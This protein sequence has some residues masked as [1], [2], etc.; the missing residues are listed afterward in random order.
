MLWHVFGVLRIS[1]TSVKT[2][3]SKSRIIRDHMI[4]VDHLANVK[5]DI[6]FGSTTNTWPTNEGLPYLHLTRMLCVPPPYSKVCSTAVG[7]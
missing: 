3:L 1:R 5:E 7:L 2:A 6:T 4:L